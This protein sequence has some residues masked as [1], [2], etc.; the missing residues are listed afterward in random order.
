MAIG[1]PLQLKQKWFRYIDMN[2]ASSKYVDQI[3]TEKLIN[4]K[5]LRVHHAPDGIHDQVDTSF[6]DFIDIPLLTDKAEDYF[7]VVESV[8]DKGKEISFPSFVQTQYHENNLVKCQRYGAE[9]PIGDLVFIHGLYEDNLE[10][11]AYFFSLLNEQG[12]NVTLIQLPFHYRRRPS[13]SLFSG[14]FFWSA[15]IGRSALAYK[16]AVYDAYQLYRY[17]KANSSK[18][19]CIVGFS[20]GGGIGL[21]LASL[22]PLD[23]LF[24]IN[25]VCNISKLT[26]NSSLFSPIRDDLESNGIGF[27]ELKSKYQIYEPLA[28]Q[29]IQTNPERV[30]LA[31]SLYDQ[32]NDTENY[33]L[34]ASK[35][36]IPTIYR[37]KAGHLNIVRV[38]RLA[39][40]LARFAVGTP[41]T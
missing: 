2:E 35:W 40:D 22:Y 14:E 26:W 29:S 28:A 27:D 10:I 18:P 25:P 9:K 21:T 5:L 11:Y 4:E 15:N 37:Y 38:P 33:G 13:S 32:I 20:M 7:R 31:T 1:S 17:V 36:N 16:Q 41:T 12:L 3:A 34:L 24:A 6:N 8:S 23:G 30:V 39:M 19:V